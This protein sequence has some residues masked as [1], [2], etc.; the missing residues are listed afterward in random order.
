VCTPTAST[1]GSTNGYDS[2]K[3][4][5]VSGRTE[6]SA[7]AANAAWRGEKITAKQA[8]NW[9]KSTATELKLALFKIK[10]IFSNYISN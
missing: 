5:L 6:H 7:G 4:C 8:I 3:N 10:H 1:N 9:L 2:V